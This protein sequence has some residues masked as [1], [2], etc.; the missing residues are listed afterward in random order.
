VVR[1]VERQHARLAAL[2][3][4]DPGSSFSAARIIDL[5]KLSKLGSIISRFFQAWLISCL[6]YSRTLSASSFRALRAIR[7]W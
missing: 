5:E 6:S 3:A 4:I 1:W 7:S 2:L